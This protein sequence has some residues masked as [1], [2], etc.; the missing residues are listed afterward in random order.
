MEKRE[1]ILNFILIMNAMTAGKV[2][3]LQSDTKGLALFTFDKHSASNVS[4]C[5]VNT[6]KEYFS[7]TV[8]LMCAI[9][10]HTFKFPY[11]KPASKHTFEC[12]LTEV[13]QLLK[14][15][16]NNSSENSMEHSR[17]LLW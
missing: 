11:R 15:F 6:W 5:A 2:I 13:F 4:R 17:V 14:V 8:S 16:G 12:S 3:K 10:A 9:V 1:Y 7:P